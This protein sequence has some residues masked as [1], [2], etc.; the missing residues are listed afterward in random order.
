MAPL[1]CFTSGFS[2]I[3]ITSLSCEI[4]V[5]AVYLDAFSTL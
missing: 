2:L 1:F 4:L 5:N 3:I